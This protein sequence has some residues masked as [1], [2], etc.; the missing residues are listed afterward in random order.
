MREYLHM[1]DLPKE[2]ELAL[3]EPAAQAVLMERLN[4]SHASGGYLVVQH[5]EKIMPANE[6]RRI[7]EEVL[8]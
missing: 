7:A 5:A 4:W 2:L 6:L 3:L 1:T 8:L